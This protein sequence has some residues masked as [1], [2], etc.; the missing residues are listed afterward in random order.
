MDVVIPDFTY[1]EEN[2]EHVRALI[3]THGHEDHIGAT[4][5]LLSEFD[6]PVYGT[7]FTLALAG[8]RLDE[9]ELSGPRQAERGQA[10]RPDR[11]RPFPGRIRPR[12]PLDCQR[13]GA[14]HH[15]A[16]GR[17]DPY[18]RLQG[19]S[20]THRQRPVRPAHAGRLRQARRT[21]ADVGF[22]QRGPPGLHRK[23]TRRAA[24]PGRHSEPRGKARDRRLLQL[25]GA[26]PPAAS[27]SGP[28]I[29][30]QGLLAWPEHDQRHRDRPF[31]GAAAHSGQ[32]SVAAA[33][34]RQRA[35]ATRCW[36]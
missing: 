3:L 31:P 30:T 2:R 6:I 27:G 16:A 13:P 11:D 29:R 34:P 1:L 18:R 4:P 25:I 22:H 10:W 17:G 5:F 26:P 15:H 12:D 36:R 33:G 28:G 8:R 9:H 35:A 24:A 32:D 19:R 21:A 14:G 23:R 20:D 7:E